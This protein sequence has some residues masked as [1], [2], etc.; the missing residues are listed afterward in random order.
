M[1]LPSVDILALVAYETLRV[2]VPT[3]IEAAFGR[4]T[5]PVCN[6][7]LDA[8]SRNLLQHAGITYSVTGREH[9]NPGQRYLVM[10]NHQSHFDIPVIFQAIGVPVRMVAKKELFRI[11]VMSHAMRI[12]G[13]VEIDRSNRDRAIT[14]LGSAHEQV[15]QT[16]SI[17][18]APEGTRSAS[19]R[20]GPFK[21]GGFYLALDVG[22]PILP[23]TLEGT[24]DA[25]PAKGMK[26]TRGAQVKVTISE[27]ID[28]LEYGA[29]RRQELIHAVHQAIE[30]HLPEHLHNPPGAPEEARS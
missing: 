14:S 30:Q 22:M 28:P 27:P 12:A 24:R 7:R 1:D 13:F 21:K 17:W 3:I 6:A 15:D 16:V 5:T 4:V 18:I 8:W 25:L 23:V 26:V 29:E 9:V 10:S 20:L 2:S 19:G 11:P